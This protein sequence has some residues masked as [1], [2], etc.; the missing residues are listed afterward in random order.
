MKVRVYSLKCG[1]CGKKTLDKYPQLKELNHKLK[2]E[3]FKSFQCAGGIGYRHIL[4]MEIDTLAELKMIID[5]CV[6]SYGDKREVIVSMYN[7]LGEFSPEIKI[8]DDYY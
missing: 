7:D 8:F 6:D 1:Y 4:F 3:V 2:R 5:C